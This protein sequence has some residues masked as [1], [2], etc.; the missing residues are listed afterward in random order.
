MMKRTVAVMGLALALAGCGQQGDG[1]HEMPVA[2]MLTGHEFVLQEL[3]GQAWNQQEG[4]PVMLRFLRDGD[5]QT[6]R[7]AG[8]LCNNFNGAALLEGDTLTVKGVA[9]TRMLCA[10]DTLNALDH[11]VSQ[12]LEKGAHLSFDHTTLTLTGD[13]H[14]L[15]YRQQD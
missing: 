13:T 12:M 11:S 8:K 7:V 2:D 5:D 10:N 3:D 14:T 4:G 9:M 15:M 6:L 1:T